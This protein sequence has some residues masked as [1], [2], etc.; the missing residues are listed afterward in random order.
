MEKITIPKIVVEEEEL[1]VEVPKLKK[2]EIPKIEI[3]EGEE[4]L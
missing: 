3:K 2:I 4:D 1:K